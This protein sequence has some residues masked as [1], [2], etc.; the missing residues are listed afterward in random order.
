MGIARKFK[1]DCCGFEFTEKAFGDGA[2]H[3]AMLKGVSIIEDNGT[4][5]LDPCLCPSCKEKIMDK[6]VDTIAEIRN[7]DNLDK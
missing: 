2:E 1:C 3:W 5:I 7:V 6:V 4:K